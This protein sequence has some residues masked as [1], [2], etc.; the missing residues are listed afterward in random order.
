MYTSWQILAIYTLP[1]TIEAQAV[2]SFIFFTLDGENW[3]SRLRLGTLDLALTCRGPMVIGG[4][5]A[6]FGRH[7][8]IGRR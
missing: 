4:N 7:G 2:F 6:M 1:E 3:P 5:L 8:G